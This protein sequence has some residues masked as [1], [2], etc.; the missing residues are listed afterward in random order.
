MSKIISLIF[1]HWCIGRLL[2]FWLI[3]YLA[4]FVESVYQLKAFLFLNLFE[5]K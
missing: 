5:S 2:T 4:D 1:F 3:V